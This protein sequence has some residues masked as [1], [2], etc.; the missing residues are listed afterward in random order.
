MIK[1]VQKSRFYYYYSEYEKNITMKIFSYSEVLHQ[2]IIADALS[3]HEML[4]ISFSYLTKTHLIIHYFSFFCVDLKRTEFTLLAS[5][6]L[7][8][9]YLCYFRLLQFYSKVKL[10]YYQDQSKHPAQ[11][12]RSVKAKSKLCQNL[13][14]SSHF[15]F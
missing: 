1:E 14:S 10:L 6:L 11:I 3:D 7:E 9:C 4:K 13:F 8:N 12:V 5:K 15:V 2:C